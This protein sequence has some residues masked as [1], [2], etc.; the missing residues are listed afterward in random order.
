MRRAA[1]MGLCKFPL[2]PAH[3]SNARLNN[4][5][6]KNHSLIPCDWYKVDCSLLF[7]LVF[8]K[9]NLHVHVHVY[10]TPLWRIVHQGSMLLHVACS[11]VGQKVDVNAISQEIISCWIYMS[12]YIHVSTYN[13]YKLGVFNRPYA[14]PQEGTTAMTLWGYKSTI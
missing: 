9:K 2:A 8:L 14:S 4:W 10:C 6:V 13:I 11:S 1:N 3:C 12:A 7:L 5:P